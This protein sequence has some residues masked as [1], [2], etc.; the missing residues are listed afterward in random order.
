MLLV[1]LRIRTADPPRAAGGPAIV[2]IRARGP[3]RTVDGVTLNDIYVDVL[4]RIGGE[5]RSYPVIDAI[6]RC[7]GHALGPELRAYFAVYEERQLDGLPLLCCWDERDRMM[8]SPERGNTFAQALREQPSLIG[9]LT[10][11]LPL[12]TEGGGDVYFA[13]LE[14]DDPEIAIDSPGTG[15]MMFLADSPAALAAMP[16]CE[17]RC[18]RHGPR[19][20]RRSPRRPGPRRRGVRRRPRGG[21]R[22][23]GVEPPSGPAPAGVG[24]RAS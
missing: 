23:A 9:A 14:V 13:S 20:L 4:A 17:R 3:C 7:A 6:E 11:S 24:P 1:E 2:P 10:H 16:D 8:P 18:L 19:A 21:R 15:E 22:G 12:G 5:A